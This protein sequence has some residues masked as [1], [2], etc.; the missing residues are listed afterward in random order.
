MASEIFNITIENKFE[1]EP[2]GKES[3]LQVILVHGTGQDGTVMP[4]TQA[5]QFKFTSSNGYIIF[6]LKCLNHEI[7]KKDYITVDTKH[8][9]QLS[10]SDECWRLK[11]ARRQSNNLY[12]ESPIH[13]EV[14]RYES[15][16]EL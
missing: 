13:I 4:N 6:N 10:F 16:R 3:A 2:E 5:R 12:Q 1:E 15:D 7:G 11:I 8:K 14:G 9:V